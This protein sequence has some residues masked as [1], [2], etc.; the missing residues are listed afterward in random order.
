MLVFFH[1]FNLI[2]HIL[3]QNQIRSAYI[4]RDAGWLC[5]GFTRQNFVIICACMCIYYLV[6]MDYIY[7]VVNIRAHLVQ[8]HSN[9][10]KNIHYLIKDWLNV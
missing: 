2:N 1:L 3:L 6:Y 9:D 5:I 4:C 10:A 7:S 8:E